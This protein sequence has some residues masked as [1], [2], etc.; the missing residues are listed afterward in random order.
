MSLGQEKR[1]VLRR[2][3]PFEGR[4][5]VRTLLNA[6]A[7]T[8]SAKDGP[9]KESPPTNGTR[10]GSGPDAEV[11]GLGRSFDDYLALDLPKDTRRKIDE[12][13]AFVVEAA[14]SGREA[15]ARIW[16]MRSPLL[17]RS[18]R[19]GR[20]QRGWTRRSSSSC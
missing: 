16:R 6:A 11:R 12:L 18:R 15:S 9:K 20:S 3:F 19:R 2:S 7:V 13:A 4:E 5:H 1:N 8:G 14:K 17:P 10:N